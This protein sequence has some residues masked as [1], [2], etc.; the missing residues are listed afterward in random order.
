ML[1]IVEE[2]DDYSIEEDFRNMKRVVNFYQYLTVTTLW[3]YSADDQLMIFSLFF[4]F[5]ENRH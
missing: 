2:N 3:A 4:F 5:S 1:T